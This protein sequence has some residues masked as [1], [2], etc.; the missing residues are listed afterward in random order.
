MP[1]HDNRVGQRDLSSLQR[2]V[3]EFR[4]SV[5]STGLGGEEVLNDNP[6]AEA[7]GLVPERGEVS[8]QC[9]LDDVEAP[10]LERERVAAGVVEKGLQHGAA[11]AAEIRVLEVD[12]NVSPP[13]QELAG[14]AASFSDPVVQYPLVD[15]GFLWIAGK[16]FARYRVQAVLGELKLD[17][18]DNDGDLFVAPLQRSEDVVIHVR[19]RQGATAVTVSG[20]PIDARKPSWQTRVGG[21]SSVSV[22]RE[23][24][25]VRAVTSQAGVF[26]F[27]QRPMEKQ[28]IAEVTPGGLENAGAYSRA[29]DLGQGRV[30]MLGSP[31]QQTV[32]YADSGEEGPAR[33]VD[34]QG[35]HGA[36]VSAAGFANQLLATFNDGSV[37]LFELPTGNQQVSPF[38]PSLQ[39]GQ[40]VDWSSPAVHVDSRRGFAVLRDRQ[41]LFRVQVKQDPRPHLA[42]HA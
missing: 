10:L 26:R 30:A 20:Q 5:T 17:W 14:I 39:P 11:L 32:M 41:Q 8:S 34:L 12:P 33:Q 16:Q 7:Y 6:D 27:R 42:L 24:N 4:G 31:G 3:V 1:M 18:I 38:Q 28:T 40:R 35:S 36:M 29:V 37:R 23:N 21:T 25:L 15:R 19:R 13:V 9:L 2:P 22:D